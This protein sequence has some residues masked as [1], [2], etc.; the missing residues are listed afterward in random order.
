MKIVVG[1]QNTKPSGEDLPLTPFVFLVKAN[2]EKVKIRGLGIQWFHQA[3]YIGLAF[4]LP[5]QMKSFYN[6][7]IGQDEN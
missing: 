7:K 5:K 2:I 6:H 1:Y 3:I 4:N